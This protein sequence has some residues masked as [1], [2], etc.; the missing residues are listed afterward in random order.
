MDF[1][2]GV[3]FLDLF[4]GLLGVMVLEDSVSIDM[5]FKWIFTIH[6]F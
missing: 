2:F 5:V 4:S 1:K 3:V 6:F